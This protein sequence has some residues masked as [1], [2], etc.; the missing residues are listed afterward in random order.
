MEDRNPLKRSFDEINSSKPPDMGSNG[1]HNTVKD[2]SFST[3][4]TNFIPR[5]YQ[6]KVFEV[7]KKRNTIAVLETGAGKTM[8]AVMLIKDIAQSI[9][10]NGDKKSIIFLAP[11]V[12]LQYDVININSNFK[13][14][15]YYG[16][17]G[18]DEW[19]LNCWEKEINQNDYAVFLQFIFSLF[20]TVIVFHF[21]LQLTFTP[22]F[23][24][25]HG[26]LTVSRD[27]TLLLSFPVLVMTPQ[28]LLDALR[29]A[30]L[31][32][33]MDFYHKSN[34]K[35]KIFGMTA[36][37]VV[38]KGVSSAMDC[39]VQISELESILDSQIYTIEDRTEMEVYVPSAKESVRFYDQ[40]RFSSLDLKAKMEVSWSKFDASLSKLQGS[41]PNCYK[42]MDDKFK[43][44]RKQLSNYHAK[45]LYC[46]D[47]LGLIC[48]YE[49]VK[50]S[51]E[52]VPNAKE[53]CEIYR[54]S[55]LQCKYFLE[56]LLCLIG[57]SLPLG[58]RSLLDCGFDYSKAVDSDYISPKLHELLQLF[59]SL[60]AATRVLCL[61]FVDRIIAAKVVERFVKKV[62]Y[63]DHLTVSYLTGSNTSVDSLAPTMQKE[64][65]ESFRCGKIN[66]LFATDVV[67]E[68]IHVPNCSCV[69]RFDLPKTVRSY[70]QSRGR[71]RQNDSQFVMML[72][73][74][75]IKQRDQIYDIIRSE[76]SMTD[77]AIKRDPDGCFL[78]SCTFE[79]TNSYTVDTT[80]ASVTVDSSV[81]LIHHYC[82]KLP[83]DK[84]YTPKPIF[85][86]KL[87]E[88]SCE[89]ELTLPSNAAFQSI[90]GP[91]SRNKNLA[92]Q[93]VCLE[94]CKKLHQMGA[95]DDHLL[96]YIDE[97]SVKNL[98]AKNQESGAG[99]KQIGIKALIWQMAPVSQQIDKKF[100]G[101]RDFIKDST[102]QAGNG[103]LKRILD[104]NDHRILHPSIQ[105]EIKE[106]ALSCEKMS[107]C[108]Y[109]TTKRKELHG[110][111]PIRALYGSWGEN[112]NDVIL[113]A[114]KFDFA[115]N[116]VS[117]IYS[118]FVLLIDSKLD[119]DVGNFELE[120]YL[121]S[122]TVK[123]TVSSCGLVHLD[124][125]QMFKAKC[126]QEF[127]FNGL[128]GK[129]FVKSQSSGTIREFLLQKET[130]SLWS[131]S[132]MYLLLPIETLNSSSQESWR[133]NWKGLDACASVVEFLKKNSFL[134][135][136]RCNGYEGNPS[137]GWTS[138]SERN[139]KDTDSIHFANCSIEANN[140][141][142]KVVLAIHTGR[143]YSTVKVVR[144][145]SAKSPFDGN[146]DPASSG[147][148]SF[149]DYF[150]K[151]YG[152]VLKHPG[153]PLLRLKQS[154]NPHN[155]LV[156]FNDEG[157]SGK[158]SRA[159]HVI[160]KPQMHVHIPPELL[161]SI[162]IPRDILKSLY[163][164]PSLMQ[165]LESLMLAAQLRAEIDCHS[166]SYHISISLILEALT[167]L[168]CCENFSMERLEL[169]GDS[170][171]KYAVSCYLFLTY[172]EIHEGQLS[173][174]RSLAVCNS[175]LHKLGT[176]RKL[177]GYI[178][179]SAFDPR[180]WIA[181]GQLS[182]RPV[183]C[184]CG[185]DTL[186]VPLD[187]KYFT[188]NPKVVVGKLCDMGHRWTGS[189]TIA[190]CVEALI[191]A[192]YI[193]GGLDAA[194]HMMK[195]LKIDADLEPSL[196]LK[197]INSASLRSY[198]PK[199]NE[200]ND[201]ES[202]ICY[203]FSVK[204]LLQEAIT[205]ASVQEF[206][207]YQ[208][209]VSLISLLELNFQQ[210]LEFLGD[211]VLDLLIT[212]H[213][214]QSH[215]DIDPGELTDLRSASVNNENF[216]QVAVRHNLY[217]HFQ[218]CSTLLLSQITEYVKSF[219]EPS[220]ATSSGSGNK[221][222]KALGDLVESIAGA[223]LIDTKLNLD[224]VWRIFK[225]LLSPIV[226][227][228]KLELPP[229][230]ELNELCDSLGYFIK[231]ICTHKGEKVHAELTLQLEDVLLIGQ[232]Y[233]QSRKTAR[234]KAALQLLKELEKR[235]ICKGASKTRKLGPDILGDSSSVELGDNDCRKITDEELPEPT[236]DKKQ[237][238]SEVRAPARDS[239][240]KA[241]SLTLATQGSWLFFRIVHVSHLMTESGV[242]EPIDMKKGGP[243]NSL[244]QLCKTM[245]WP[246]P[247]FQTTE[248]KS[249]SPMVFGE[250]SDQ[251]KGFNSYTSNITL[252]IP[253]S[254][255]IECSGDPRAD[256]KSSFDSAAVVMIYE[257]QR[258]GS[259]LV[260][261]P[262]IS[263]R[264]L[265]SV[266]EW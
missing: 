177:Q 64:I 2:L 47:E 197:A 199:N 201:L 94:A 257:L 71:A 187:G 172:P 115:C 37:P 209:R 66:L 129:L 100:D 10:S 147:Y 76:S 185:V 87:S 77:T 91:A 236:A 118:G 142:D 229:Q 89:C 160:G 219:P 221:A 211:S 95:L 241:C 30:F 137:P 4:T 83:L 249:R 90:V 222:P 203:E 42:D 204:F 259:L 102:D 120:L 138:S 98:I 35:P 110:T 73:R 261:G 144:D 215:K 99:F 32:L 155:L 112:L 45:I 18:V 119:D 29:K 48:A 141:K 235:G 239:S 244:F 228:D 41:M 252:H 145:K 136:K 182:I 56:E 231:E 152:I 86:Y 230:R 22:C 12:H 180:R 114:Y 266:E 13:V 19:N 190:D 161:V 208:D 60:G 192:Y 26:Q 146:D 191:G 103:L 220:D 15:E 260:S 217:K 116:I 149:A 247:T 169:L 170:V 17:I 92:K 234:G 109:G 40:S 184:Q 61:I 79:K 186:E 183:P 36:S 81:S 93:L 245:L 212:W 168:R 117:E 153:Q 126:F 70:V 143:I 69:I 3:D 122:K 139:C 218:H 88:K 258:Q 165:R 39:E 262:V 130:K 243:R 84:Y 5:E 38:R 82:E 20:C 158:A 128:F 106:V 131:A 213:L 78:R 196:V 72:E 62:T 205:H 194:L 27:S 107:D 43:T 193:G 121:V 175:T 207:C 80:G 265:T 50:V 181:P 225:P 188:N 178:R 113:H 200:I 74:G 173:A 53:E 44:L 237:K 198:V 49:A 85:K 111:I 31:R 253:G 167:T 179:D 250:G 24:T 206:Y 232:G 6:L 124:A 96:P 9:K 63:L 176:D 226:T 242:I 156:N 123:A 255:N 223:I 11:T 195:W 264:D 171:L 8:I 23:L 154:H 162:D 135:L 7:A 240:M 54:Q 57:E 21:W 75:N 246:M 248:H 127:F 97:T 67:E 254:G 1:H 189:K 65:L 14:G 59:V 28:I 34:H 238:I 216:A 210:R 224:E 151:K 46:L 108:E 174:R 105:L 101:I 202:K 256:K 163:L 68:G 148:T 125:E 33:E 132:N 51:L 166:S 233:D 159:G 157:S 133:I 55:S 251:R 164:L 227:P 140:L 52:N 25:V 58:D 263:C 214:Y 104:L 16:A 134:S 150:C